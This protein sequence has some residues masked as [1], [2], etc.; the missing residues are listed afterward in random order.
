MAS[1]LPTFFNIYINSVLNDIAKLSI[2]CRLGIKSCNIIAYADDIVLLTPSLIALQHIIDIFY[3]HI[4]ELNLK[5]N[6]NKSFC[7]K[8]FNKGKPFT[9]NNCI[10]IGENF[11]AFYTEAK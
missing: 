10:K 5:I 3:M 1:Y 2:G 9:G 11:L 8:F 6:V 7:I 4:T